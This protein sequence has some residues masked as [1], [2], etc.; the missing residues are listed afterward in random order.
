MGEQWWNAVIE[1]VVPLDAA[2]RDAALVEAAR[3]LDTLDLGEN[4]TA[5]VSV[6]LSR[7]NE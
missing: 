3:Y 7:E 4:A 1:I 5:V 6:A 2:D